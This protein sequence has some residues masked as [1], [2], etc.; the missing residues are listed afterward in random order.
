MLAKNG[1][2]STGTKS[3]HIKN[4]IFLITGKV[5]LED[6]EIHHKGTDEMWADVNTKPMRGGRF[7]IM[8]GHVM[9]I[10]EDYD[11]NVERRHTYPLLL[12]KI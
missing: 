12:P 4:R 3:K 9:G 1:R 2:M 7:R 5:S 11:Y 8:C 6:L 10:P